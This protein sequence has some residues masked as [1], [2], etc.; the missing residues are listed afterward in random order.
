MMRRG[1]RRG[2]RTSPRKHVGALRMERFERTR[3][4]EEEDGGEDGN[5]EDDQD[6]LA[7][8]ALQ[9][10][11]IVQDDRRDGEDVERS[12]EHFPGAFYSWCRLGYPKGFSGSRPRPPR[13]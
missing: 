2:Y 7:I 8:P 10:A 13:S 6:P 1:P 12:E 11:R 9:V 3:E 4:S 5:R